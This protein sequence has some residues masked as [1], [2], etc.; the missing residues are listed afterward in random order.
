[1]LFSTK[2]LVFEDQFLSRCHCLVPGPQLTDNNIELVKLE[3]ML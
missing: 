3:H 1:M 2:A